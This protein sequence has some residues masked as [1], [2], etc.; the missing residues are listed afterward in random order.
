VAD[1]GTDAVAEA[2]ATAQVDAAAEAPHET[3]GS[4][5]MVSGDW[6]FAFTNRGHG[7]MTLALSGTSISGTYTA[8][9]YVVHAGDQAVNGRGDI[10]GTLT[11]PDKLDLHWTG[12]VVA[13]GTATIAEGTSTGTAILADGPVGLM[14]RH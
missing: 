10:T 5:D 11:P 7:T 3:G 12:G 4:V 6:I 14:L 8:M 9:D 13:S 1:G 2:D